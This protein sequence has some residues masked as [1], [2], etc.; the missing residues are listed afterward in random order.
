MAILISS[1]ALIIP[2]TV[3][4]KPSIGAMVITEFIQIIFLSRK[5][6]SRPPAFCTAFSISS[7]CFPIFERPAKNIDATGPGVDSQNSIALSFP[8]SS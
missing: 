7:F 1:N 3:P 8:E 6:I 5:A 4:V 2:T